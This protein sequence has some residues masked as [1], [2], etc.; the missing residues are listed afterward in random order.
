MSLLPRALVYTF[1]VDIS[2]AV[3]DTHD[4]LE[5][6][7]VLGDELL[8]YPVGRVNKYVYTGKTNYSDTDLSKRVG[9]MIPVPKSDFNAGYFI[10]PNLVNLVVGWVS[11]VPSVE[12][13]EIVEGKNSFRIC[14]R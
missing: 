10:V 6:H 7:S 14:V 8:N 11:R 5:T 13:L 3:R 9:R 12:N 4:S 1:I 2:E